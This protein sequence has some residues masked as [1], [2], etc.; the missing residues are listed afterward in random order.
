M[1]TKD[2]PENIVVIGAGKVGSSIAGKLFEQ[3]R[4]NRIIDRN[5]TAFDNLIGIPESYFSI[6]HQ[7]I[8]EK[9]RLIIIAIND[10]LLPEIDNQIAE[11][12]IWRDCIIAHTSGI[13]NKLVL[14][15][16]RKEC[17]RTAALHPY[18]TFF[19]PNAELL[20]GI[21]W[22][23]DCDVQDFEFLADIIRTINGKPYLLNNSIRC[24][25]GLYHSSA[26]VAS[27]FT[28]LL[29]TLADEIAKSA[30]LESK[31]FLKP[32]V[33]Q[34]IDNFFNTSEE[35]IPLTGPIARADITTL[36]QHIDSLEQFPNLLTPYIYSCIAAIETAHTKGILDRDNYEKLIS[37]LKSRLINDSSN[38]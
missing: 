16:C 19:K 21:A 6:S 2:N 27:N 35:R 24:F 3:G 22:G 38:R 23:I 34:T 5:N 12:E 9:P 11:S 10:Y 14:K 37:T 28:A 17:F 20:N 15:E 31:E 30:G 26:V 13:H 25:K 8:T 7:D 29:L 36:I 33:Y 4:L 32:I 18:Q 1:K